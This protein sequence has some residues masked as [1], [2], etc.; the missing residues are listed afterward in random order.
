MLERAKNI[1]EALL[2]PS[3]LTLGVALA[4][5]VVLAIPSF[6]LSVST[7][8]EVLRVYPG[9]D[10]LNE[11]YYLFDTLSSNIDKPFP[12]DDVSIAVI[13][14]STTRESLTSAGDVSVRLSQRLHRPVHVVDL[15]S[16]GQQLST[17]VYLSDYAAC[18]GFD[19]VIV[20]VSIG[21]LGKDHASRAQIDLLKGYGVAAP[22]EPPAAEA[23][24]RR[25]ERRFVSASI[26]MIGKYVIQALTFI[27]LDGVRSKRID[28]G[29][30]HAFLNRRDLSPAALQDRLLKAQTG[31]VAGFARSGQQGLELLVSA[32]Q[33]AK[34][35][36]SRM[37][38]FDT[39]LN[40]A[41]FEN[42]DYR[43]YAKAYGEY[44]DRLNAAAG[45]AGIPVIYVNG[46]NLFS[47]PDFHD[48]GHLRTRQAIENTTAHVTD[49][50]ANLFQA[51]PRGEPRS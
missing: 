30:R 51:E 27:Q 23:E 28:V 37:I 34:S 25:I 1:M 17:S 18:H 8:R 36:G 20:G 22:H 41:L 42:P 21:R 24:R 32:A 2:R 16:S 26:A 50:L 4:M 47:P 40:P 5:V 48:F 11:N 29:D 9:Y 35:C 12:H 33:R 43:P 7:L 44:R 6:A 10:R 13:G 49:A 31:H 3:W 15:A 45:A 19:Y 46:A 38:L 39:P 14:G